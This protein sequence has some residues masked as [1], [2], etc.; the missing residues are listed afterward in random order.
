MKKV[1]KTDFTTLHLTFYRFHASETVI[2]CTA[3]TNYEFPVIARKKNA[4]KIFM[5]PK[6]WVAMQSLWRLMVL[7][8]FNYDHNYMIIRGHH[9]E[10]SEIK[11]K[12]LCGVITFAL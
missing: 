4:V 9:A 11:K 8:K 10:P 7:R 12:L 5:P 3:T 1:T 2:I 6:L